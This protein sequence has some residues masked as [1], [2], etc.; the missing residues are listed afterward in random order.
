MISAARADVLRVVLDGLLDHGPTRHH[1]PDDPVGIVREYERSDDRELVA[2]FAA[3][4]AY[5]RVSSIRSSLRALFGGLGPSPADSVRERAHLS[6]AWA[7]GF[8]HRWTRRDD[9]VGLMEA[10]RR[11]WAEEGS[12]GEALAERVRVERG[13]ERGLSAWVRELRDR[14]ASAQ[15]RAPGRPTPRILRRSGPVEPSRGLRF[16]LA[17]PAGPSACKRLRLFLRWMARPDDG[18]DLGVWEGLVDPAELIVPLDVHWAR[19][20]PRLGLARRRIPDGRMARELSE[21]LRRIRPEDPL[22]YDF[23]VCHLGIAGGCPG[24]ITVEHCL[25]CALSEGCASGR[26]RIA[27]RRTSTRMQ[28]PLNRTDGQRNQNAT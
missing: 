18:I 16:L 28:D 15:T 13:F 2:L 1:L 21:N 4:L 17:D 23:P 14:A 7:P 11:M 22:V 27:S 5:G 19:I 9:V 24:T 12:L 26:R 10:V 8:Q 25:G 3:L 20:G 6:D